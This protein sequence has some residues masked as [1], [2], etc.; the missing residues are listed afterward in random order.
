MSN[1]ASAPKQ[2]RL[3]VGIGGA[4]V[5]AGPPMLAWRR[6]A[7][8][9]GH[10]WHRPTRP[11]TAATAASGKQRRQLLAKRPVPTYDDDR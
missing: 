9:A 7:W 6:P 11:L 10:R 3:G 1:P 8:Q 5:S 4:L 2:G